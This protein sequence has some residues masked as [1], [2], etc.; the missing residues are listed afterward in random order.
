MKDIVHNYVRM[1]EK[2]KPKISFEFGKTKIAFLQPK[3]ICKK[4]RLRKF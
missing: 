4:Q 1:Q 3:S 2:G